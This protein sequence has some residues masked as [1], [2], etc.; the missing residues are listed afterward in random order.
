[1]DGLGALSLTEGLA[2]MIAKAE[3]KLNEAGR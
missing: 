3:R 1:M 2:E